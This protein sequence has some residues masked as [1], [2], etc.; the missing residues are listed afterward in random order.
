MGKGDDPNC[1]AAMPFDAQADDLYDLY[2]RV[3][4]QAQ[5][6]A[7][8]G[9]W[10]DYINP[11]QSLAG[12]IPRP[13]ERNAPGF[14]A[15]LACALDLIPRDRQA[16]A[17]KLHAAYTPQAVAQVIAES[18]RMDADSET[19]W[20]LAACSVCREGEV[21][22][23]LFVS[24]LQDFKTLAEDPDARRQ[25][26]AAE[27]E[28]MR[29]RFRV[30]DGVAFA[31]HDGGMQGAYV[32]GHKFAAMYAKEADLFFIGTYEQSLGL[33]DFRWSDAVDGDGRPRS[34]GVHGSRQFV[35]CASEDEYRRAI[36]VVQQHFAVQ[37]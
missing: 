29:N 18:D 7:R 30:R 2:E 13:G 11:V 31:V 24:Q 28:A 20:W 19:A 15:G 8:L 33:D 16:L 37:P 26:A 6:I 25:A 4:D 32:S 35:K 34:G 5:R 17:A 23:A 22:S 3:A 36:A 21:D 14:D 12:R 9:Q 1:A 10:P 27:L